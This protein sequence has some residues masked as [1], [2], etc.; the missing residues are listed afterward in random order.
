MTEPITVSEAVQLR[1][2]LEHDIAALLVAFYDRTGLVVEEVRVSNE[3]V[4]QCFRPKVHS[5]LASVDVEVR[6]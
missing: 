4:L 6:L 1:D 2:K 5:L 3:K